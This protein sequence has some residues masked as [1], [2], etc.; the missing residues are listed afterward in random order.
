MFLSKNKLHKHLRTKCSQKYLFTKLATK[1]TVLA[2]SRAFAPIKTLTVTPLSSFALATSAPSHA[3]P[4]PTSIFQV[5][6]SAL[7]FPPA[8]SPSATPKLSYA[9][10]AGS[11]TSLTTPTTPKISLS[12][13]TLAASASSH[14]PFTPFITPKIVKAMCT[15]PK[16]ATYMTINLHLAPL[17]TNIQPSLG[18]KVYKCLFLSYVKK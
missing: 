12:S 8:S 9:A 11:R 17:S 4:T 10:I 7:L 3:S 5:I 15:I 18:H 6:F 14:T 16:P 1:A 2:V 13:P